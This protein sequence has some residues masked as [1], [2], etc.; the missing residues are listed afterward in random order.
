[1]IKMIRLGIV[2]FTFL[3]LCVFH[4]SVHGISNTWKGIFM[5]ILAYITA[6]LL[7]DLFIK[8]KK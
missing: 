3:I 2:V 7:I 5:A 4:T 8:K 1:M 6:E